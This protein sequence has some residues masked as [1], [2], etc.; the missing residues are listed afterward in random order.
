MF[1]PAYLRARLT[2]AV[3]PDTCLC[4]IRTT[5]T[6]GRMQMNLLHVF[7]S[8]M[9]QY[10]DDYSVSL[11]YARLHANI[12]PFILH[13]SDCLFYDMHNLQASAGSVRRFGSAQ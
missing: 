7:T 8:G 1:L 6:S 10:A 4:S 12:L 9:C 5:R 13:Y 11:Y 2:T 3:L